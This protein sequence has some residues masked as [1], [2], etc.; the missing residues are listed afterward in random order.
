[1]ETLTENELNKMIKETGWTAEQI[2][3]GYDIFESDYMGG[4]LHIERLDS[5]NAFNTDYEASEQA[6]KDGIKLI[7]DLPECVDDEDMARF[8]DTPE[9]RI[10]ISEHLLKKYNVEWN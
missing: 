5:I 1:M 6:E 3:K 9:N 8:I 10:I 2:K 7:D 4:T